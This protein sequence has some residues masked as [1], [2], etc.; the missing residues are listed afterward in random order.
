ML[1]RLAVIAD[2]D[3]VTLAPLDFAV[4]G[5]ETH[6]ITLVGS[7]HRADADERVAIPGNVFDGEVAIR[8]GTPQALHQLGLSLW[9]LR[10]AGKGCVVDVVVG[11]EVLEPGEVAVVEGVPKPSHQTKVVV[12]HGRQIYFVRKRRVPAVNAVA[13]RSNLT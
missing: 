6:Q 12:D 3:E 1:C 10:G 5:R 4:G 8:E 7:L 2:P 9:A 11:E 13:I